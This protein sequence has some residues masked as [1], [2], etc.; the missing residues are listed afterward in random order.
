MKLNTA[1][2][3]YKNNLFVYLFTRK[4]KYALSLY[5]AVN[6]THYTNEEDL[7][8]LEDVLF[9][10]MKNDASFLFD[11]AL[12]LYEHQSTFTWN[13][14]LRGLFYFADLYRKLVDLSDL[15][16]KKLIKIPTPKYVVFY[17]GPT[18]DMDTD[19]MELKLSDAFITPDEA[20]GFEWTATVLN[21]NK[22]YNEEL[23]ERCSILREYVLFVDMVRRNLKKM[24]MQDAMISAIRE[25]IDKEILVEF[26]MEHEKEMASME[27][28]I[29]T[30]EEILEIQRKEELADAREE[31]MRLGREE[32]ERLGR[33]EGQRLGRAEGRAEAEHTIFI[34]KQ[35]IE[36]LQ[37]KLSKHK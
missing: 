27:W 14:P 24:D 13:M 8:L 17:N 35:E 10:G 5:N 33:E 31:A 36:R 3:K 22:G 11:G 25:C 6:H 7:K 32:G 34:L 2:R 23:L 20:C 4:K 19:R 18:A 30:Y 16:R 28:V 26:L 12:N 9:I 15:Y 21:I 37:L 29:P 1:N